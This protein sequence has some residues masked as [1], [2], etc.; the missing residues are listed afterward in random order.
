MDNR[1][2]EHCKRKIH[3]KQ[4]NLH[5]EVCPLAPVQCECGFK[6]L[7]KSL[8]SHKYGSCA[9]IT[10]MNWLKMR[11]ENEQRKNAEL[12]RELES[13]QRVNEE[14]QKKGSNAAL[15]DLVL[16]GFFVIVA[17]YAYYIL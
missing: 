17:A 5:A 14:P 15:F 13:R 7:R 12:S 11:T 8:L 4:A 2:C 1:E 9:L 3:R 6:T 16:F 10:E